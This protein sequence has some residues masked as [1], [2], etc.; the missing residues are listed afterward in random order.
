MFVARAT[1]D[2]RMSAPVTRL[3]SVMESNG[4][5]MAACALPDGLLVRPD[6]KQKALPSAKV[7]VRGVPE[8]IEL[9]PGLLECIELAKNCSSVISSIG[10]LPL[11]PVMRI[12]EVF[13]RDLLSATRRA[14]L[15]SA[16]KILR[17]SIVRCV[18][19]S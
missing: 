18:A 5:S 14:R 16:K 15:G 6:M 19:S 8:D 3:T 10:K 7:D 1:L 13:M 2:G 4:K 17:P 12:D 9:V 11:G